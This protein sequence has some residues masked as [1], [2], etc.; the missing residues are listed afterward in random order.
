LDCAR[1][2]IKVGHYK[3]LY[4]ARNST[5]LGGGIDH[6]LF[7]ACLM[8]IAGTLRRIFITITG[9]T[10]AHSLTLV[11]SALEIVRVPVP[12]VEATI[13]L[14]IVF[15]ATE[16]L[17]KNENSLTY[18]YPVIVSMSFGLLHGFG[19]AAV[20]REIGLPQTEMAT[21]L[22]FFNVGVE[23]G[24]I[25]FV[26]G[27]VGLFFSFKRFAGQLNY[28]RMQSPISYFIGT[29]ACFWF[30]ERVASFWN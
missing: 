27:L 2:R 13:A 24:Q 16:I 25:L 19:F 29:V 17:R 18:R 11:L 8:F 20:L 30:I 14:S 5:Y 15:L 21:S 9:F 6:L 1:K 12:P 3:R 10:I 28:R 22:L 4:L 26:L 7:V 23:V